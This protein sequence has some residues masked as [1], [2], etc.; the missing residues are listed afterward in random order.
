MA[1]VA[2]FIVRADGEDFELPLTLRFRGDGAGG[3]VGG[4]A[5]TVDG[6]ISTRSANGSGWLGIGGKPPVGEWQLR[7]PK[8]G[9]VRYRFAQEQIKDILFVITFSGRTPRWPT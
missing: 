3:L 1:H 6:L 8:T 4:S 7:V 5:V 9:E 2:V